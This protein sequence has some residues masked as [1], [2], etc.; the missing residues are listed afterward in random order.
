[1]NK[2]EKEQDFKEQ[3]EY[4]LEYA[5]EQCDTRL[6]YLEELVEKELNLIENE[7]SKLDKMEELLQGGGTTTENYD[8][9][10]KIKD[11]LNEVD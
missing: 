7:L 1:M 4:E 2:F 8:I 6:P 3:V 9:I 11:I 5:I 10:V